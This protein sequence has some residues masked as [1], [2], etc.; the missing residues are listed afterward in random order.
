MPRARPEPVWIS[1]YRLKCMARVHS[2]DGEERSIDPAAAK[3]TPSDC[4]A[5]I[6]SLINW[7]ATMEGCRGKQ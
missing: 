2:A 1:S 5:L 7:S 3:A 4:V 6:Q